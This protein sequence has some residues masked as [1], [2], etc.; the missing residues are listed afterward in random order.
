[1]F[2]ICVL[3]GM[4]GYDVDCHT[5]S[6][7]RE[8]GNDENGMKAHHILPSPTIFALKR[9]QQ[10]YAIMLFPCIHQNIILYYLMPSLNII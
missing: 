8:S 9:Q 10:F 6:P 3:E 5:E 1:M 2:H 7:R 4:G